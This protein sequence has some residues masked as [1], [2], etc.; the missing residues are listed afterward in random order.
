SSASPPSSP[1]P[2]PPPVGAGPARRAL[3]FP[4]FAEFS[5]GP[6]SDQTPTSNFL[7]S[8]RP[9]SSGSGPAPSLPPSQSTG[10]GPARSPSSA[11]G[12]PGRSP[13]RATPARRRHRHR[14]TL[15]LGLCRFHH[16]RRFLLDSR[17]S[18][19]YGWPDSHCGLPAGTLGQHRG[20]GIDRHLLDPPVRVAPGRGVRG[21]PGRSQLQPPIAGA[22]QDGPPGLPVDLPAA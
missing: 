18:R 2:R 13:A 14:L 11:G 10:P 8:Q 7:S 12:R 15:P 5:H 6:P 19:P 1:H 9:A 17:V 16:R 21:P 20:P 22:P 4:P 3:H